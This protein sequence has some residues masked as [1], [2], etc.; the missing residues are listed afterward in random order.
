MITKT[1]LDGRLDQLEERLEKKIDFKVSQAVQKRES[2]ISKLK[3]GLRALEEK[4]SED[5]EISERLDYIDAKLISG[6]DSLVSRIEKLEGS[7][8]QKITETKVE[9]SSNKN[10]NE[11]DTIIPDVIA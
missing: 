2:E 5:R 9:D 8:S 1:Y 11:S 3:D 10:K 4:M 6:I 7:V